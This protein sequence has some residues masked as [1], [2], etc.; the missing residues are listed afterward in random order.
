[1]SEPKDQPEI[2]L[3]APEMI[4][5]SL[6]GS[7]RHVDNIINKSATDAPADWGWQ[8]DV[9]GALTERALCKYL[10]LYHHGAY[11]YR[12]ADVSGRIQV[13]SSPRADAC[14]IVHR[15]GKGWNLDSP[16][17]AFVLITGVNGVYRIRGWLPGR[18]AQVE[19]YWMDKAGNGRP[20][21]FVPQAALLPISTLPAHLAEPVE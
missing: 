13:R 2:C 9:E 3:T 16:D 17:D 8:R 7:H 21:Y 18:A 10:G 4:E 14:L 5:G 1:M 6:C 20:A 15:P 12:T 19:Q 11:A